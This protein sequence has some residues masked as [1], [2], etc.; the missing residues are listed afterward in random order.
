MSKF[1]NTC[2][3]F[4]AAGLLIST[5]SVYA[6]TSGVFIH[7]ESD[8]GVAY[9]GQTVQV[10]SE[11]GFMYETFY[12]QNISGSTQEYRWERV[13]LSVTPAST[14]DQVCDDMF[15]VDCT[16]E[17]WTAAYT[18]TV[19]DTDS[20]LFKPQVIF[21]SGG[22]ASFKYYV[23]NGAG[24][25]IDSVMVQFTSTLSTSVNEPITEVKVYPNPSTGVV[26]VK[27]ATQGAEIQFI[28]MLGKLYRKETIQG[29][30]QT[31]NLSELPDGVYFYVIKQPDGTALPAKKLIVR[32]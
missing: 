21:L 32:H 6:Q 20:S 28:D 30:T 1:Y 31:V 26:T 7:R 27:N 29:A 23:K 4:F 16:G 10:S 15:C 2:V 3:A 5:A 8:P 17:L 14:T 22:N 13:R 9:N 25:R 24:D 11:D 19:A 12:I 18:V